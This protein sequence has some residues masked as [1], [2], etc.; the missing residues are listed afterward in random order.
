SPSRRRCRPPGWCRRASRACGWSGRP[1]ARVCRSFGSQ[2]R[3]AADLLFP[4]PAAEGDIDGFGDGHLAALGADPALLVLPDDHGGLGTAIADGADLA[5]AVGDGEQGL[6]SRKELALEIDAEAEG[7]HRDAEAVGDTGKLPD[8]IL[9]EEL[10]FVD[11]Y[12]V[13][14]AGEGF[15]AD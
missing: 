3:P 13:D 14:L 1:W 12:A 4:V 10:R 15:L 11:Q 8:L 5:Q 9:G 2:H 7:H 6:R